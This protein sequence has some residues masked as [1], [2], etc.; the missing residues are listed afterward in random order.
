[1]SAVEL[2]KFK[3]EHATADELDRAYVVV[4]DNGDRLLVRPLNCAL[5]IVPT[6]LVRRAHVE[7]ID[8][9]LGA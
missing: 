8:A 7:T 1:V 6:E 3:A 9:D 2:V 5:P 4:E